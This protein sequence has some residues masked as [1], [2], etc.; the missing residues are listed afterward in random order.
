MLIL[1]VQLPELP[2]QSTRVPNMQ[3]PATKRIFDCLLGYITSLLLR[4]HPLL[5]QTA[6]NHQ[7]VLLIDQRAEDYNR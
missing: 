2:V 3:K 5:R 7:T 1:G 6:T 4:L